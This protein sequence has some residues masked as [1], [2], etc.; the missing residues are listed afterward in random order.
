MNNQWSMPMSAVF[1]AATGA[2]HGFFADSQAG[3]V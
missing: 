1:D 2:A 3:A